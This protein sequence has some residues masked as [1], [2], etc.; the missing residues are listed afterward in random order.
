MKGQFYH[1]FTI[2]LPYF[3]CDKIGIPVHTYEPCQYVADKHLQ[4]YF[5]SKLLTI[6]FLCIQQHFD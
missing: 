4:M 3:L 2:F 5:L 6:A 1:I